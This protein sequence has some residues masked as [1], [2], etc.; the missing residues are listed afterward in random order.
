MPYLLQAPLRPETLAIAPPHGS[1]RDGCM[2]AREICPAQGSRNVQQS[3]GPAGRAVRAGR[4][5]GFAVQAKVGMLKRDE[6]EIWSIHFCPS[7][8]FS[9]SVDGGVA[10]AERFPTPVDPQ[11]DGPTIPNPISRGLKRR[12]RLCA[13][14]RCWR[15]AS[16]LRGESRRLP[17]RRGP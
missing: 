2:R 10:L 9:L 15:G 17:L 1:V 13:S 4:G 12:S 3:T 16:P 11:G 6:A 7:E 14:L 8:F 5:Y